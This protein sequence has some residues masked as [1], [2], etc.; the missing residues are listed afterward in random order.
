MPLFYDNYFVPRGYAVAGVDLAGTSRSTG[1]G[2]VGGATRC[3]G[4]KA[5]IDWLNG[6]VPGYDLHGKR[7]TA[8]WTNGKV[9]MIGKIVGRLHRQRRRRHRRRR[10]EDR[11][12]DLGISS[13]YDYTRF[14]G[15]LRSSGLRRVP[16]ELR[17][18]PAGRR[19][20]RQIRRRAGGQRRRDR[21]RQRVLA[22]RNYRPDARRCTR[23]CSSCT[24]STTR[25]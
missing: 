5:A 9:G 25:T 16:R 6:R 20:R 3:G 18:R 19:V 1:C 13:W 14:G 23:A 2:D 10:T 8:D 24:A 15:V 22:E 17:R 7:V 11:R 4:A 12:A 21:Q